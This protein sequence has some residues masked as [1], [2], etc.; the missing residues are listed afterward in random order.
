[1]QIKRVECSFEVG[2]MVYLML[3]PYRQSTLKR[4]GAMM[5]KPHYYGL[6]RIIRRVGEVSYELEFL[7]D[8]RVHNVF[9]VSHLKKALGHHVVPSTTFPSLDDEGKLILVLDAI[10]D[11]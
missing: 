6:F 10:L 11:V 9:H 7:D 8:Y 3:H 1:M 5:L 4:S 2:D